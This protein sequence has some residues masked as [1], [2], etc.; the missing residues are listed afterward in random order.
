MMQGQKRI[1]NRRKSIIRS[2]P[3]AASKSDA[4][5]LGE[6]F[7]IELQRLRAAKRVTVEELARKAKTT[8]AFV[9]KAESGELSK[10]PLQKAQA[11]AKALGV[12]VMDLLAPG[13]SV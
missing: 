9:R 1:K 13:G 3:A 11:L 4:Q 8:P 6:R 2:H 7:A 5:P 12:D 10:L